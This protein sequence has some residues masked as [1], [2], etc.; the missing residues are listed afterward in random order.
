MTSTNSSVMTAS[1]GRVPYKSGESQL[2]ALSVNPST[3]VKLVKEPLHWYSLL[4]ETKHLQGADTKP[5]TLA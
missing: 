5:S 4:D 1:I 3:R 2:P